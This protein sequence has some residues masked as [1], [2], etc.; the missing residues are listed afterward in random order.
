MGARFRTPGRLSRPLLAACLALLVAC[1][2]ASSAVAA[3]TI[4]DDVR[5]IAKQLRCP[6]CESVSVADSPAELAV[7]MRGVIRA[8]LEAGQ[9]EQEILD[10]FVAAYGDA[11]LLEPP[12]RG[13]GWAAW[14]GPGIALGVGAALLALLLRGWV[15][16]AGRERPA[17]GPAEP[18]PMRDEATLAAAQ[19]ELDSVRRSIAG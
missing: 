6:V 8:K 1:F 2:F 18:P 3:A 9:S 7:Q 16:A 12:R 4:D 5:R 10:Y 13:L 14:L 17:A 19:A 15:R 11:V